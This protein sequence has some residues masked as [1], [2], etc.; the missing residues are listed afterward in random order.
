MSLDN[1]EIEHLCLRKHLHG[2]GCDL[3]TKRL[4]TTEQKLLT[5]LSTRVKGPRHLRAAKR[6]ICQVAAVFTS[7]RHTLRD[8]LVDDVVTDLGEPIHVRFARAKVTTFYCIV[9]ET[10]NAVAVVLIIFRCVDSTLC[11]NASARDAANPESKN[12]SPR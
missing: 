3:P 8:A 10:I 9:K 6:A 2:T 12:I 7:K 5:G 11:R 1:D 4:I